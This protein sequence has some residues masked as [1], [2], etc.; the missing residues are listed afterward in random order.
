MFSNLIK[1]IPESLLS[2]QLGKS[3]ITGGLLFRIPD[4]IQRFGQKR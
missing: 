3:D 4:F 1:P 2:F